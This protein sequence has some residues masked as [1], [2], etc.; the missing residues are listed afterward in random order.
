MRIQKNSLIVLVLSML[1]LPGLVLAQEDDESLK[2]LYIASEVVECRGEEEPPC[3][4]VRENPEDSYELWFDT[5]TGFTYVPGFEYEITVESQEQEDGSLTYHLAELVLLTPTEETLATEF[6]NEITLFISDEA[7]AC[8]AE[9]EETCL[10]VKENSED[11]FRLLEET[12]LG[13][14]YT[15]GQA[16][17]VRVLAVESETEDTPPTYLLLEVL[18]PETDTTESEMTPTEVPVD[19][20]AVDL[21]ELD[22][23]NLLGEAQTI[24]I[25]ELQ[26]EI[27]APQGFITTDLQ[28]TGAPMYAFAP[29]STAM[30]NYLLRPESVNGLVIISINFTAEQL[31]QNDIDTSSLGATILDLVFADTQLGDPQS[32]IIDGAEAVTY[33]FNNPT[34]NKSGA[35]TLIRFGDNYLLLQGSTSTVNWEENET[36]YQ[37]VLSSI[38]QAE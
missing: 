21:S 16:Y 27:S 10:L 14:N 3:L 6:E 17:E 11:N 32:F 29:D 9:P 5:I 8:P 19:E 13:F 30:E 24:Q 34:T 20:D 12:I 28:D 25:G 15:I 36:L 4:L 37:A 18:V 31:Q 35:F 22:T 26:I 2:T 7:V 23:G 33:P 1:I 38:H